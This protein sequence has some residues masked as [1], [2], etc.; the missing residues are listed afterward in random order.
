MRT[1][2][3]EISKRCLWRKIW[4]ALAEVEAEFGL[5][6]Q[7]QV[8]ELGAHVADIDMPRSLDIEAKIHHD[9][10]AELKVYTTQCPI[11]EGIIH[12]GATSSDIED[13]TDAIRIRRSLDLIQANLKS[14]LL[15]LAEQIDSWADVAVIAYTHLQPA[16]VTTL[17]YRL[18]FYAQ[19]LFT[20]W[21]NIIRFIPQVRGKG[22]RGA[23]GNGASFA[24]LIG[25]EQLP[26]FEAHLSQKLGLP[27]YDITS[28][29]YPRKQDYELASILAGLGASLNKFAFDLRILQT[30]AI[31]E[32]T[33][34]FSDKQIG[35]SAMPFK[36]NP[37]LAEKLNSLSRWLA[38]F[39]RLAWDNAAQSLLERTLDDSANRRMLLPEMFLIVDEMLLVAKRIIAGLQ[40]NRI[41]ITKNLSIYS[42]FA[43]TERVMMALVK[44]GA[45][46]Q[47]M[48]AR[49]REHT[50]K[51]WQAVKS[52][53]PNPLVDDICKDTGFLGYLS[54]GELQKLMHAPP[55]IGDAP[56]R[57]HKLVEKIRSQ[58]KI[59]TEK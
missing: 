10:M 57:A 12:L 5:V 21:E 20:D 27:F 42:P 45:N 47:E 15:L 55:Q 14:L 54:V 32:L 9:L 30:P 37:I 6:R 28:Q 19:D 17:G 13:N 35:S 34:P 50:L 23:V 11:A 31:G 25:V 18:A 51:A 46:R 49:L 39:P 7:E 53:L 26:Q 43:A 33:E 41:A 24:E 36:R 2:W 16:E 22:I 38:Q 3:S 44:A 58:L 56:Q 8:D 4:L 52:S 1:I 29:V 59:E 48:H 40:V